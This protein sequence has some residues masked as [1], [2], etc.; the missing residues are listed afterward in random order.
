[1]VIPTILCS[2]RSNKPC[3]PDSTC[4]ITN[5]K[6]PFMIYFIIWNEPISEDKNEGDKSNVKKES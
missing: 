4:P 2:I 5:E 6:C 1:M 3:F